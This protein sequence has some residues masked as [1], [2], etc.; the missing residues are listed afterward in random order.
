M[1]HAADWYLPQRS[2]GMAF[3][4][5]SSSGLFDLCCGCWRK[6]CR[7]TPSAYASSDDA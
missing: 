5:W 6:C 4:R 7:C 3:D 2:R 1:I